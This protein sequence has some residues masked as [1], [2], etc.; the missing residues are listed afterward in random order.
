MLGAQRE[1][2][3]TLLIVLH[4]LAQGMALADHVMLM[5]GHAHAE[6]RDTHMPDSARLSRLYAT[7]LV[8]RDGAIAPDHGDMQ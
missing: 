3:R 4:D 5:D 2:G 6:F 8:M 7:P 1:R